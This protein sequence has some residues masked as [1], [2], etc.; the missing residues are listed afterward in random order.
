MDEKLDLSNWDEVRVASAVR[1]IGPSNAWGRYAALCIE[2]ELDG[3]T[4]PGISVAQLVQ[5]KV[6]EHHARVIVTYF[7]PRGVS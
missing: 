3:P 4:I 2:Q 1:Q 7:Q 6:K 5:L